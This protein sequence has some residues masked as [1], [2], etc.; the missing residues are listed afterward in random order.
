MESTNGRIGPGKSMKCYQSKKG[1]G[2]GSSQVQILEP[3]KNTIAFCSLVSISLFP[4]VINTLHYVSL[5]IEITGTLKFSNNYNI[6]I[7]LGLPPKHR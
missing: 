4:F 2:R 6:W 5:N 7:I 1:W 3:S